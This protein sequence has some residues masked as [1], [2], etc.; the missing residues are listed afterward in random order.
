MGVFVWHCSSAYPSLKSDVATKGDESHE[1][2]DS[3]ESRKGRQSYD[4]NSCIQVGGG[5]DWP[6]GEGRE[7]SNGGLDGCGS[8]CAE[9]EAEAEACDT[10]TE[11]RESIHKGT[12]R[13]QGQAS[14]QDGEGAS[15]EKAQ[16]ARE[17]IEAAHL[18]CGHWHI[19]FGFFKV[20]VGGLTRPL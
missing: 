11:R 3:R 10:R 8:K 2:D 7:G 15:H 19:S 14:I 16:G 9:F 5:I 17:L 12:L 4:G 20:T 13:L 1:S 6:K 18:L